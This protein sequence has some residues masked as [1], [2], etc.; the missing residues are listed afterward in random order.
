[1]A[2]TFEES[3]KQSA[4]L[5]PISLELAKEQH[6]N[7]TELLQ[8]LISQVVVI[9]GGSRF[10]DCNFIEDT[11]IVVGDVAVISRMGAKAREGEEVAVAEALE[12]L[13]FLQVVH[14]EAP[15]KMDGGDILYTGKHLF[16]GLSH[17]TNQEA[18][19]QLKGLFGEKVVGVPVEGSLHLKSTVSLFDEK[20]LIVAEG[21]SVQNFMGGYELIEVPDIVASN[22]LRVGNTLI[23]QEGFP[24]SEAI[25]QKLCDLRGVTLLK[26]N[27]SELIKADGALTCGSILIFAERK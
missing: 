18:L 7:Y 4:P 8:K 25:L 15:A 11:A 17:R 16:V 20:T 26:L 22:V 23:I 13:G 27:M 24:R 5:E 12:K 19:A 9:E 21:S 3:L 14:L 2:E 10:P 6:G 1:M